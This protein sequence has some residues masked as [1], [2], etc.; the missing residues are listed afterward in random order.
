MGQTTE[1]IMGEKRNTTRCCCWVHRRVRTKD[2]SQATARN[3]THLSAL[4]AS[5]VGLRIC[6]DAGGS[7]HVVTREGFVWEAGGAPSLR[8]SY[9]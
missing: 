3:T 4:P 7:I 1:K 8:S 5:D 6:R 9:L 2:H